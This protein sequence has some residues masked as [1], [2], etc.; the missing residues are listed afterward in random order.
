[1]YIAENLRWS[2][3]SAVSDT[4]T[5]AGLKRL[6]ATS[7]D[8]NNN[9][10]PMKGNTVSTVTCKRNPQAALSR[11]SR[12]SV[13][14]SSQTQAVKGSCLTLKGGLGMGCDPPLA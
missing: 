14:Y 4:L 10:T 8:R 2:V 13:E 11:K 9:D 6:P 12:S 7:A 3:L 1:M 5:V